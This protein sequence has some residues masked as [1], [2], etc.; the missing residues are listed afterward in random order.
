MWNDI[1]PH[2]Q[3]DVMANAKLIFHKPTG[4]TEEGSNSDDGDNGREVSRRVRSSVTE[5]PPV[6]PPSTN[7]R[8]RTPLDVMPFGSDPA[9]SGGR[10]CTAKNSG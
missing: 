1:P 5:T 9:K 2:Q 4:V 10:K 6:L 7:L 3:W 8:P